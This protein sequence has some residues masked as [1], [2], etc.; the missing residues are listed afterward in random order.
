LGITITY[1]PSSI[2]AF[3]A[4]LLANGFE[5]EFEDAMTSI[6][7]VSR[8]GLALRV[9]NEVEQLLRRPPIGFEQF[10]LDFKSVWASPT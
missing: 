10:A 5:K 1:K 6:D 4:H 3:K 8:F 9:T 2:K 7:L